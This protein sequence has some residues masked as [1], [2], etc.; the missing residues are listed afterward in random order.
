M[1]CIEG[2]YLS[3]LN[4]NSIS[5]KYVAT[6]IS[7]TTPAGVSASGDKF[8]RAKAAVAKDII[9]RIDFDPNSSLE[10][11]AQTTIEAFETQFLAHKKKT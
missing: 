11:I 10:N 4:I 6:V 8:V 5:L 7:E 3:Q 1:L 2:S 9:T